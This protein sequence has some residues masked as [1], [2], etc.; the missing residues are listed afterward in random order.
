MQYSDVTQKTISYIESNLMEEIQLDVFPAVIGYSKFHLLRIFRKETGKSIGEYIRLRRLTMAAMLLLN[1]DET[2]L[3][4][5]FLFHFQSQE[6]FTR[7]FKEVYAVPPGKYRKL[8][9]I[10]RMTEEE[11]KMNTSEQIK[12]WSLSGSNPEMYGLTT[13]STVCHTGTHSG[14]LYAKGD[15]N[16]QQFATIMQGFQAHEYKG[17]RLK[18]SCFLTTEDA[19]KCGAWLRID[20]GNG[21]T[22]Q[23]DNMDNRSIQGTT[24]WNHYSLVLDVPKDS[25][26]IHFGVLLIGKGKVWA[27]GFRFEVVTDKVPTTNM[28]SEEDLPAQP[29]NLDFSSN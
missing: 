15:V 29:T 3:T 20:N 8:M 16:E 17:E 26:S 21:D 12:G 2:I 27:D 22:V 6:A 23:F 4:I 10:V 25:A 11:K 13:D 28:L 9:K 14:L 18:L 19:S 5:A 1:S 24:D 7:A